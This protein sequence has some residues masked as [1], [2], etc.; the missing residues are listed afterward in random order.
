MI[1]WAAK[2]AVIKAHNQHRRLYMREISI[3]I[4][5]QNPQFYSAEF[6]KE[7]R[8]I[9]L[10]DP[11]TNTIL[12]D[13]KVAKIRKLRGFGY[14]HHNIQKEKLTIPGFDLNV[15]STTTGE[16]HLDG[17]RTD[18]RERTG[19]YMRRARIEDSQRQIAEVSI[20]HDGDSAVAMCMASVQAGPAKEPE[21]I[22]DEG[23]S[24]PMH[25]TQWGD[26]G[27]SP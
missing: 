24:P 12:M 10:I 18:T 15:Y 22:V 27:F 11:P 13:D 26:H 14:Q 8:L 7:N 20:S 1:R 21:F 4:P 17:L 19:Y 3:V 9:A 2:E 5:S 6:A 23:S 16:Q 25:E